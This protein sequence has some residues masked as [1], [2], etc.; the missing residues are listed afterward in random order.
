MA[1]VKKEWSTSALVS[2]VSSTSA[3]VNEGKG[4]KEPDRLMSK[5]MGILDPPTTRATVDLVSQD[6]DY[7]DLHLLGQCS[8]HPVT[9]CILPNPARSSHAGRNGLGHGSTTQLQPQ[10]E[11]TQAWTQAPTPDW[12]SAQHLILSI[13]FYAR[14][15][16]LGENAFTV[17]NFSGNPLPSECMCMC[18]CVYVYM[19]ICIT[20]L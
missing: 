10:L 14:K 5:G 7:G 6:W 9:A 3:K 1:M 17:R 4:T 2:K 16:C 12:T 8:I 13:G 15:F 20:I 11:P 19:C 18:I